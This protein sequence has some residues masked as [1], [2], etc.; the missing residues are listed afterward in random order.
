MAAAVV[1]WAAWAQVAPAHASAAAAVPTRRVW[2]Q[3]DSVLLGAKDDV[4]A[5]LQADGWSPTVIAWGGL[6]L[7]AA[8]QIFQQ[9]QAD[10]GP[11]VVILLGNNFCCDL[12]QFPAQVDEAMTVLG[13]RHVIWL[14]TSLFEPRQAQ[15]NTLIRA[16]AARWPNAEV[17]DWAAEV[18]ANPQAV[19]PDGLH[20]TV[21]GRSL[22][23]SFVQ[24]RVDAWYRQ[25]TGPSRPFADAYGAAVAAGPKAQQVVQAVPAAIATTPDGGGY[26]VAHSDGTVDARGDAEA[27]APVPRR[28]A[29]VVGLAAAPDG[30]G[31][32]LAHSDGSV[33]AVG[34]AGAHGGVPGGALTQ[35]VVG[36]AATP[37]GGGYWLVAADGGVFAFGDAA[38][39]GSLGSVHLNQPVVGMAA[40]PDG[41]GYWLVAADGGVFTF[42]DAAFEGS[43]GALRLTRPIQSMAATPD[44]RGYWLLAADGGVFTFGDATFHGSGAGP[45]WVPPAYVAIAATPKGDG[46]WLLGADPA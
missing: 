9:H 38:Y 31:Y 3:G 37:D 30:G 42:G 24:A 40:T 32:W 6:Q 16:G 23:A 41:G 34:D 21:A 45:A 13:P 39:R 46:Y 7:T 2:V 33:D 19:G 25:F 20:L 8:I 12:S 14:T 17:A 27:L 22:L 43:T 5:D 26:W 15:I 1:A 10:I 11:V 18:T 29:P 44:G 28:A 36:M 35:P 4:Q